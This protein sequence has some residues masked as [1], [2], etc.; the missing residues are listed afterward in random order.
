LDRCDRP[1]QMPAL[2]VV[3]P[4]RG[5]D[6]RGPELNYV[7]ALDGIRAIAVIV[8]MGYHGGL[9]LTNGGFYSLDTFFALSGFLITTLLVAEWQQSGGI[10]LA[11]FWARRA[12]RLL[13]ALLVLVVAVVAYVAIFSAPG[14][15]PGLRLDAFSTLFYVA[16]WHFILIGSNYFGHTGPTSP[17]LHT[18]S[19]AVEEQFY[20]FWPLIVIAVLRTRLGLRLLL[21]VCI[22]GAL[23]SAI[24]MAVLYSLADQNRVYYGTDT[25]AQSLLVGAALSVSL[26]LLAQ[27]RASPGDPT[28]TPSA[29]RATTVSGRRAFV[30]VGIVGVGVTAA[31]W[32]LV[33][34]ND[35]FAFR[36]GFLL[37][38]IA[39]V[40]VLAS[41]VVAPGSILTRV[42]TFSPLRYIGRISYGMYLWHFPLVLWITHANTGLDEV[43]LFAVRFGCTVLIATA[44]FYLV[45]Q[46]I[47]QRRF[48]RSSKAAFAMAPASVLAV[49]V[50]VVA[51]TPLAVTAAQS[52]FRVPEK[53]TGALYTGPPVKLLLVGDSTAVTL[54]IGLGAY[55]RDYDIEMQNSGILGCGLTE[56]SEY[57]LQGVVAPMASQCSGARGEEQWPEIWKQDI[58]TFQPN[59]VMILAGR[60]EVTNRT[61]QGQWTNISEPKYADYVRRQL[62]LAVRVASSKGAKVILLTA[63]CYNTGE[64]PN[65]QPWP[66][67]SPRRLAEY[68]SLVRQ[69]GSTEPGTTVVNFEAMACPAGH[70]QSYL[71][72]VDVRY[73]GVHFTLGGGEVFEPQ[74]FPL[75]AQLGREQ[76]PAAAEARADSPSRRS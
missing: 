59:V 54:G 73:D 65:G 68:N 1:P 66:E 23:G 28:S 49:V 72:G 61:Y 60:W 14:T 55:K 44:S 63:P 51:A 6:A 27:R 19:L 57:E 17:L 20:L 71:D 15:Y 33:S 38:A 67:D 36:G 9:F 24:L 45:E 48:L 62:K 42:L 56:G 8:I 46:P 22:A 41:V 16:N 5:Q 18:W 70:Y 13:P 3:S 21:G 26:T 34:V 35:A 2:G 10:R 4:K 31:L 76:M 37:A 29:W 25:R 69:V 75:V 74:L 39:T 30:I 58:K 11:R 40:C 32:I 43:P 12:R 50:A 64:Q 53:Q 52:S 47:R 7:P